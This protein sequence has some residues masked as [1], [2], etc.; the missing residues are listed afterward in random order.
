MKVHFRSQANA[1][2]NC[3]LVGKAAWGCL[4]ILV[5]SFPSL[6]WAAGQCMRSPLS[7]PVPLSTDSQET[8]SGVLHPDRA[9]SQRAR[10]AGHRSGHD[11]KD[12]NLVWVCKAHQ[13]QSLRPSPQT[14]RVPSF[15]P[16]HC[17]QPSKERDSKARDLAEWL[18]AVAL[19][20]PSAGRIA[21]AQTSLVA[22]V[23]LRSSSAP[24][25]PLFPTPNPVERKLKTMQRRNGNIP[26]GRGRQ[27][28]ALLGPLY[29]L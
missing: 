19:R 27:V 26:A 13:G 8:D 21:K 7:G 18:A 16:I 24:W 15:H 12:S 2:I 1:P 10:A 9:R 3:W 11:T 14:L 20:P 17:S 28:Q 4:P 29:P 23:E 25:P 5:Y 22:S 6:I